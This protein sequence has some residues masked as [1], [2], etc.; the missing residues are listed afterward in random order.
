MNEKHNLDKARKDDTVASPLDSV[1][2][3]T[4]VGFAVASQAL[5]MWFGVMSGVARASREIFESEQK[6][7]TAQPLAEKPLV[8]TMAVAPEPVGKA[9]K[10]AA[11]AAAQAVPPAEPVMAKSEPIKAELPFVP[12]P[13]PQTTDATVTPKKKREKETARPV[14]IETAKIIK[15]AQNKAVPLPKVDR[16]A[17]GEAVSPD[18]AKENVVAEAVP[19]QEVPPQRAQMLMPE[20]FRAPK[21]IDQPSQADDLKLIPGVGPKLEQVLNSLGVWTFA[22][23]AAWQPEEVAWVEDFM[24]LNGRIGQ[25]DWLGHAGALAAGIKAAS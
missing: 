9:A 3:A 4:A 6:P 5:E 23:V 13:D 21:R 25:D 20:D 15:L 18:A 22:Q 10:E 16:P 1:A 11:P 17:N 8:K 12:A 24:G 19:V 7:S 2:A 14:G